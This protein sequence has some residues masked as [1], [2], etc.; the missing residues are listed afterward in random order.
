MPHMTRRLLTTGFF[1]LTA[2]AFTLL[3][4]IAHADGVRRMV[5]NEGDVFMLP[6]CEGIVLFQD[7][8]L[9]I[10]H[11]LEPAKRSDKY[12]SVDLKAGDHLVMMNG[13]RLKLLADLKNTYDSLKVGDT[14]RFGIKRDDKLMMVSFPKG[15]P[16]P[17]GKMKTVVMNG[18]SSDQPGEHHMMRKIEGEDNYDDMDALTP[19][20][21]LIGFSKGTAIIADVLPM[22]AEVY[23]K[24]QPEAK[25]QLVSVDGTP[26]KGLNDLTSLREKLTT[27]KKG[28]VVIS[29]GGKERT[30]NYTVPADLPE[31]KI[32]H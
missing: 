28:T 16:M 12:K 20:G 22:A 2:M 25:D 21:L 27:G 8:S 32:R 23:G 31:I 26:V 7:S 9:S 5:L 18:N 4:T 17:G 10:A 15:E 6:E 13:R 29:H 19:L 30:F 14:V 1:C 11:I 3:P 24:E